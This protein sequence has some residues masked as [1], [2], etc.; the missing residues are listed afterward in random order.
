MKNI[1]LVIAAISLLFAIQPVSAQHEGGSGNTSELS[2]E[3]FVTSTKPIKCLYGYAA[4]KVGD[5][6][7][8]IAIFEDYIE[9]FNSVYSMIWLAQ[10][11]DTGVGVPRDEKKATALLKRGAMTNDEAGYSSLAQYHYGVALIEG[12]GTPADRAAGEAWLTK[13]SE[14]GVQEATDYLSSLP[15]SSK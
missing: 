14:A 11:Y 13:A 9:R 6:D 7:A 4:E 2:Y 10:I 1:S 12:K 15:P 8:A 5:H 3:S